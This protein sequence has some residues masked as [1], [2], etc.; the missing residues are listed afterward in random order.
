MYLSW[1]TISVSSE[2]QMHAYS[3]SIV[4][5]NQ[6]ISSKYGSDGGEFEVLEIYDVYVG[7]KQI[8]SE[9]SAGDRARLQ[10]AEQ[11]YVT[12]MIE[13]WKNID[14]CSIRGGLRNMKKL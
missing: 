8:N 10:T 12:P 2:T 1:R 14:Y 3:N 11:L 13:K 5:S 4:D 7:L 9:L 6:L